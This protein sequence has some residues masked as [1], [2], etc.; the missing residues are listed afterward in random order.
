MNQKNFVI[1]GGSRGIGWEITRRLSEDGH[2]VIVGSRSA[3]RLDGLAGV[4]HI[5]L[6]VTEGPIPAEHVPQ[7]LDGLVYCPGSILLRPFRG[8]KPKDFK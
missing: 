3:E 8:L 4:R 2:L 5:P 7:K 6:D 1:I